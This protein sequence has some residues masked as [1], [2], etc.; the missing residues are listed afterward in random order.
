M[1]RFR[2]Y[3]LRCTAFGRCFL[4]A[5]EWSTGFYMGEAAEDV[6][7]PT[8]ASADAFLTHWLTFWNAASSKIAPDYT[9]VG[10]RVSKLDKETGHVLPNFNFYKYPTT[11]D[12]GGGPLAYT[13]P[14]LS[15]VASFQARPD[16]GLGAK[17][18]MFLPGVMAPISNN[19]KISNVDR[20]AIAT[21]LQTMFTALNADAA[22]PGALINASR[23]RNLGLLDDMPVNRY[24]QDILVGNVYDT[25]RR[26]RNQ[27]QEDYVSRE[28][29]LPA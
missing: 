3:V 28:I 10:V 1:A 29:T 27:L 25:Q 7:D 14:Q 22:I 23:G 2:H 4:G 15:L 6:G 12:G 26:R 16:A 17:G 21:N 13:A 18:R 20:D 11:P 9:T 8:Q 5:E 24:V 19:G